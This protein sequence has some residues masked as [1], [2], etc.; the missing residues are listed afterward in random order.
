MGEVKIR[1]ATEARLLMFQMIM[2]EFTKKKL[3]ISGAHDPVEYSWPQRPIPTVFLE[4]VNDIE[5]VSNPV[6]FS[7]GNL[8]FLC[9]SGDA[10]LDVVRETAFSFSEGQMAMLRWRLIAP[11]GPAT[12]PHA[13]TAD[14]SDILTLDPIPLFYVCGGA[15]H[16]SL[17]RQNGVTVIAIPRFCDRRTAVVLDLSTG[18]AVPQRFGI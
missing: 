3:V 13:A 18:E 16:W 5:A 10:V 9:C 17:Q 4:G 14:D 6:A 2:R 12:L 8:P 15:D 11:T 7:V 1:R